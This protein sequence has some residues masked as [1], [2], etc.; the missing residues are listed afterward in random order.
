MPWHVDRNGVR[1][2][3][4]GLAQVRFSG[5]EFTSFIVDEANQV[6]NK[7]QLGGHT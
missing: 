5:S 4:T 6:V 1:F 3:A 2:A 7:V